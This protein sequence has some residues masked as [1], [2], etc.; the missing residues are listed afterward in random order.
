MAL[1]G[2][3]TTTVVMAQGLAPDSLANYVYTSEATSATGIDLPP[4]RTV[5][6]TP[7]GM[8]FTVQPRGVPLARPVAYTWAKTGPNEGTYT[9]IDGD[10]T[11]SVGVTFTS[12]SAGTFRQTLPGGQQIDGMVTFSRMP[13]APAPLANIATRATLAPGGVLN[14]GFVV[15]GNVTRRVLIRAVGPGLAPFGVATPVANPTLTVFSGDNQ[16]GANDDHGEEPASVGATVGAFALPMNSRDAAIV[17]R[18][19]PGNYTVTIRGGAN[20]AGDVLAEVYF[21]D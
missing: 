6:L 4:P 18:L 11:S 3:L 1:V 17:L 21:V 2:L 19:A 8:A 5:F 16:I 7:T 14:P 20:D 15:A 10:F 13:Q 9:E 12:A